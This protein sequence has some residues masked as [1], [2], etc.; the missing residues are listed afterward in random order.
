MAREN[1]APHTARGPVGRNAVDPVL[2]LK[3][4]IFEKPDWLGREVTSDRRYSSANLAKVPFQSWPD[5]LQDLHVLGEGSGY[6][7]N[8]P[9][10]QAQ[11]GGVQRHR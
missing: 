8:Y 2:F 10:L 1:D 6:A 5:P 7:N 3:D 9:V 4:K 11:C